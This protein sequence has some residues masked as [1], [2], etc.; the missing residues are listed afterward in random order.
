MKKDDTIIKSILNNSIDFISVNMDITNDVVLWC[1]NYKSKYIG[2]KKLKIL[3]LVHDTY[4]TK[5]LK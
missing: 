3:I 4:F 5:L 1:I 2:Y